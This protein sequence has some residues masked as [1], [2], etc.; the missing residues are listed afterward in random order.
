L[1]RTQ[2]IL[3][4]IALFVSLALA[5]ALLF[6]FHGNPAQ[7]LL[8]VVGVSLFYLVWGVVHHVLEDEFDF[9][10]L[11]DYLLIAALVVVVYLLA[12]RY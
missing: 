4:Y 7:Q 5:G 9:E 2:H 12:V 3:L 11:L 1:T 10:V 6:L 8:V